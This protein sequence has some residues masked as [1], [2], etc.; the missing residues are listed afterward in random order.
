MKEKLEIANSNLKEL[1]DHIKPKV[2]FFE[3]DNIFT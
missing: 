3:K 1:L 2:T